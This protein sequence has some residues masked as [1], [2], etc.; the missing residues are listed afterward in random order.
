[1]H[2]DPVLHARQE[3]TLQ[4]IATAHDGMIKNGT[5]RLGFASKIQGKYAHLTQSFLRI[6]AHS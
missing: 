2:S 4:K 1:V 3:Q 5:L 6:S